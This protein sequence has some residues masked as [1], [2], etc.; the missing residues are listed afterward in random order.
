MT[1]SILFTRLFPATL[2]HLGFRNPL[3]VGAW[4]PWGKP[5]ASPQPESSCQLR[6]FLVLMRAFRRLPLIKVAAGAFFVVL[7]A[8]LFFRALSVALSRS[9]PAVMLVIYRLNRLS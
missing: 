9:C 6:P 3:F 5:E 1:P 8:M 2:A 7:I 4:E